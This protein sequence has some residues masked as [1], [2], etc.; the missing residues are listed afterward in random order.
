V[1]SPEPFQGSIALLGEL[2]L[3]AANAG[4]SGKL[5]YPPPIEIQNTH[6]VHCPAMRVQT[7]AKELDQL[8]VIE[9]PFNVREHRARESLKILPFD[10][11]DALISPAA[12]NGLPRH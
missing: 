10:I 2:G 7:R 8:C 3:G 5:S 4:V 12:A 9:L 11:L 6:I 1:E